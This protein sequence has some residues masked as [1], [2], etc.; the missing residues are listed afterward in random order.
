MQHHRDFKEGDIYCDS[1]IW[2]E[3]LTKACG[4]NDSMILCYDVLVLMARLAVT[5]GWDGIDIDFKTVCP[6]ISLIHLFSPNQNL[7]YFLQKYYKYKT[8]HNSNKFKHKRVHKIIIQIFRR[9]NFITIIDIGLCHEHY[10]N[11]KQLSFWP[12]IFSFCY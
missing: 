7:R 3:T 11:Q 1:R 5:I 12:I 6:F 4:V 9:I 8:I 10:F 2:Y